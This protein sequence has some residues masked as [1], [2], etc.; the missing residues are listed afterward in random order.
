MPTELVRHIRA[1]DVNLRFGVGTEMLRNAGSLNRIERIG[2]GGLLRGG[3][4][5]IGGFVLKRIP[6]VARKLPSSPWGTA[7]GLRPPV[8]NSANSRRSPAKIPSRGFEWTSHGPAEGVPRSGRGM[9]GC[10]D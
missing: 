9:T 2:V 1:L 5:R 10:L 8:R 6:S 3:L 4:P 7:G